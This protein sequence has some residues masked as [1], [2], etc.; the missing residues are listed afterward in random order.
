MNFV[1]RDLYVLS[2]EIKMN[3]FVDTSKGNCPTSFN[4][5]L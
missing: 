2:L 5:Q 3:N 4:T 1:T